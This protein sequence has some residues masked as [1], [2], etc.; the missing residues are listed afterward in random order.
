[1]KAKTNKIF[2]NDAGAFL[3]RGEGC[4]IV[5]DKERNVEKYPLFENEIGE[6]QIKMGN[7]VSS[8][9]L[10]SCA[11][12]QINVLITT[13][14]GNPV[15]YLRSLDDDSHVKTRV[16]QYE[17]LKNEKGIEIAKKIVFCK[18]Q[19]QNEL[20]KKYGLRQHDLIK[21]KESLKAIETTNLQ[22]V[23][24]KLISI[25]GKYTEFYFK[26]I[27]PMFPQAVLKTEK[28]KTFKAYDGIN[29]TFNLAYTVLKWRTLSALIKAKL[30]PFLGLLHSEQFGK[31]SLACDLMELYRYLVD[32]F[33]IQ[34]AKTLR[35]RDFILQGENFSSNKK[36][37][38]E[39]LTKD[40]AKDMMA[41]LN[42]FFETTV[43]I[44]RTNH[45]N[46]QEIE[47]LICEEAGLLAKYLRGEK[48]DWTPRIAKI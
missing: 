34:F 14:R 44:A 20:L 23:R 28:R 41:K 19:G 18:A 47:S 40:L 13:Q 21:I 39:Y 4:L 16:C 35:K 37:K 36:G 10:A 11:F 22:S 3:G 25:E 26:Q 12:W 48:P 31:P 2:L 5:R 46:K 6:V 29:N 30:E 32:D 42:D 43:D 38:R 15:A 9:A 24:K 7:S 1:M 33:I 8:A 27:F 45:G 17:A